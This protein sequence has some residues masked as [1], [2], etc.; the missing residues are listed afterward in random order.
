MIADN[1]S[2]S[3]KSSVKL[4]AALKSEHASQWKSAMDD[5]ITSLIQNHTW[6]LIE[7]SSGRTTVANKWTF[8]LKLKSNG[9]IDRFKARLVAEGYSQRYG[10][11]YEE[12]YAPTAKSDNI[13]TLL[14]IAPTEDCELVQFDIKTAFLHGDLTE[15]VYMDLPDGYPLPNSEGKVCLLRKSLYGLKQASRQ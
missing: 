2:P 4:D 8:K 3:I 6:D 12:T 11:D 7:L 5:E 9:T 15:T 14:S 1:Q 10:I 13:K